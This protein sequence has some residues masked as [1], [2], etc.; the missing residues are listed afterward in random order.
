MVFLPIIYRPVYLPV[1]ALQVMR[2]FHH[3]CLQQAFVIALF[4]ALQAYARAAT[5]LD[6][7]IANAASKEG[8]KWMEKSI[9]KSLTEKQW[10]KAVT[11]WRQFPQLRPDSNH[12]QELRLGIAH[13]M[14]MLMLFDAAEEILSS[15]YKAN[16]FSIRGERTMLELARLWMDRQDKTGVKNI[17]H[18]LNRHEC[19]RC[20]PV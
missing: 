11:I 3:R 1:P 14:R 16:Q 20:G 6:S 18:W 7:H 5:S 8:M 4:P 12:S 2:I 17:M 19:N 10:L 9:K 15:L 13:A